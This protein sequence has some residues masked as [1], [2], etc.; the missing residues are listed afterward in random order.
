MSHLELNANV[1]QRPVE[2]LPAVPLRHF[3]HPG[4]KLADP[5]ALLSL[6]QA[7]LL[8]PQAHHF[9]SFQ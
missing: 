6:S 7:L 1:L 9:L 2:P 5:M 3:L 8:V 4:P